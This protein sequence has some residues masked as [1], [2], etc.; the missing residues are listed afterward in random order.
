MEKRAVE[1]R[2]VWASCCCLQ[3]YWYQQI[4]YN[5]L[6]S[7]ELYLSHPQLYRYSIMRSE[8][9]SLHLTHPSADIAP[10]EQLG[11]RCLAKSLTSVVNTSCQSR[12]SNPQ[13]WVTSGFKSNALSI[14]PR[15]PSHKQW[16]YSIVLCLAFF[17]IFFFIIMDVTLNHANGVTHMQ[18]DHYYSRHRLL[19]WITI[20]WMTLYYNKT[21]YNKIPC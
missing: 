9:C 8:M 16:E 17:G 1:K 6:S 10:G 3:G 14:R 15:L 19:V 20:M 18:I 21:I 4:T 11:V 13:P 5:K 7:D 2:A 12:D